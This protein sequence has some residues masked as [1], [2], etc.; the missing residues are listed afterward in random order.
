MSF[1]Q[2]WRN[3]QLG[4][5]SAI[6]QQEQ[7]CWD[8]MAKYPDISW[9]WHGVVS[10][11]RD[12]CMQNFKITNDKNAQG[13]I[14]INRQRG[15]TP[16]QFVDYI[17]AQINERTQ[18]IYLAINRFDI[19]PLNDLNIEY[20]D[21]IRDSIDQIVKHLEVPFKRANLGIADNEIDGHHFVGVHGLDI[22]TYEH[23]N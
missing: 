11:F 5:S 15:A 1:H 7:Y 6:L 23:N 22:F 18:A 20:R 9:A 21:S 14:I 17:N 3:K 2:H 8:F 12:R 16:K 19:V 10:V 4:Y 13:L